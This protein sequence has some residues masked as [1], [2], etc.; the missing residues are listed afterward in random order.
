M[1]VYNQTQS[2]SNTL[3]NWSR[4]ERSWLVRNIASPTLHVVASEGIALIG[5][6][7]HSLAAVMKAL[8]ATAQLLVRG[9]PQSLSWKNLINNHLYPLG[10]ALKTAVCAPWDGVTRRDLGN[11]I[12]ETAAAVFSQRAVKRKVV[13]NT[14]PVTVNKIITDAT[15]LIESPSESKGTGHRRLIIA[16]VALATAVIAAAWLYH[17]AQAVPPASFSDHEKACSILSGTF[18]EG[19]GSY[20]CTLDPQTMGNNTDVEGIQER[21]LEVETRLKEQGSSDYI[22]WAKST[23]HFSAPG[24][25]CSPFQ[26]RTFT[27]LWDGL[28]AKT[29]LTCKAADVPLV[30]GTDSAVLCLSYKGTMDKADICHMPEL[31]HRYKIVGCE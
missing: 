29:H 22:D 21:W 15:P 4:P 8:P 2:I 7:Y 14:K 25:W 28:A 23:Y 5:I 26:Q 16:S 10:S 27:Y 19:D 6:V 30:G 3:N 9:I 17:R 11:S 1:I 18:E 13:A 12:R 24:Q 31:K 20:R